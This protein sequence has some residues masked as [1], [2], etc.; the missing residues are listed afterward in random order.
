MEERV[1]SCTP[2]VSSPGTP[3]SF[4]RRWFLEG[5]GASAGAAP[6]TRQ[7]YQKQGE[8]ATPLSQNGYKVPMFQ[9]LV[10]RVVLAA[11]NGGG[12]R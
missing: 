6:G 12:E 9:T 3:G 7:A 1:G 4:S 10:R 2:R 5:F 8:K 11:L